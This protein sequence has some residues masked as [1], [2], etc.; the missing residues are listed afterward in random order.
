M[1]ILG[2]VD[3]FIG[4]APQVLLEDI[5]AISPT[6]VVVISRLEIMVIYHLDIHGYF[7]NMHLNPRVQCLKVVLESVSVLEEKSSLI[8]GV[9]SSFSD[10]R[11]WI[12]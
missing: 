9:F 7:K 8:S 11:P 12:L 10:A 2:C 3:W 6:L 1:D 5:M 4:Y